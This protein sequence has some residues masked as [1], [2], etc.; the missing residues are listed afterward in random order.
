MEADL[1]S[2]LE[3]L[4]TKRRALNA[5]L[6]LTY[7]CEAIE[8]LKKRISLVSD[9]ISSIKMNLKSQSDHVIS[10]C[11]K[12][13]NVYMELKRNSERFELLSQLSKLNS[14]CRQIDHGNLS[15]NKE[16]LREVGHNFRLL[17]EP[18]KERLSERI[19]LPYVDYANKLKN[20]ELGHS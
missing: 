7:E 2:R 14:L 16:L 17:Y 11:D 12:L 13:S 9:S 10:S 5:Q 6:N 3:K 1:L 8:E 20:L 15:N 19:D 4:E 18:L